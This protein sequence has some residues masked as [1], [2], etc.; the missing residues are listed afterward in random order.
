MK[1]T[2]VAILGA[3]L[4]GL[5]AALEC[6]QK[7]LDYLLIE[8]D[9]IVGG[10][11]KTDI[12]DGY[13]LDKGFQVLST[14]YPMTKKLLNY[15]TLQLHYFDSGAKC[16]NE[17]NSYY[18]YNPLRHLVKSIKHRKNTVLS[19]KDYVKLISLFIKFLLSTDRFLFKQK[20]KE[21]IT[22]LT[23]KNFSESIIDQFFTPFFAGVFLDK[24]LSSSSRLFQYYL[25]NFIFGK[26]A[27]PQDGIAAIPKQLSEKCNNSKILLNHTI[28][29]VRNNIIHTDNMDIKADYVICALDGASSS[30]L[31]NFPKPIYHKTQNIYF[32]AESAIDS[33]KLINL[34]STKNHLI[35]NFHCVTSI[36]PKSSPQGKY[37][38][39]L[40][41]INEEKHIDENTI[42]KEAS[43]IFGKDIENWTFLK[44][45]SIKNAVLRQRTSQYKYNN[46]YNKNKL[47]FCGD[48][49]IQ[50]SIQGALESGQ[51]VIEQLSKKLKK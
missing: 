44:E 14:R 43:S 11:L 9:N 36:N 26:T 17:N 51:I 4:A 35:N 37:L 12:I 49:T 41:I 2:Q 45:Y 34:N 7:G 40:S 3:G 46:R 38:Y 30:K 22:F 24:E 5:S 21:I 8:K 20:E 1:Q 15:K 39:S 18:L 31:F 6:E 16:W 47:Y 32:A 25:K 48:W 23:D 19:K 42:K 13:V 29:D 10:Q 33:D 50:G 28:K 27:I